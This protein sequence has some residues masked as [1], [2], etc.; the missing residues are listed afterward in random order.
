[1]FRI[2]FFLSLFSPFLVFS[3]DKKPFVGHDVFLEEW[4]NGKFDS[5]K[6][7]FPR[8]KW[9]NGNNGVIPE[10]LEFSEDIVF[11]KKKTVLNFYGNGDEYKGSLVG[12]EGHKNR[13]GSMIVSKRFFASGIYET[14]FKIGE[15]DKGAPKGMVP[16]IW[17]YA[18]R[19][20]KHREGMYKKFDPENPSYHPIL[21]RHKWG[22]SE[23][24]S[25][26]DFPEF[27][28][29]QKLGEALF[30]TFLNVNF[31]SQT[32]KTPSVLDGKYHTLKMTWTTKLTPVPEAKDS[33]VIEENGYCWVQSEE[34]PF[35]KYRGNPLKKLGKDKYVAYQGKEIIYELDGEV[36][37]KSTSFVPAMAAQFTL[38]VWFPDWGG[39]A[40]WSRAK[41]SIASVKITPLKNEGDCFG[42]LNQDL[43]D[44][45]D[46][47]GNK[48]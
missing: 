45:F 15:S 22:G 34:I 33:L 38:G 17:T 29:D 14:V 9:G 44:N 48:K 6:W 23:Y 21:D 19:F 36:I 7:Y 3:Q 30:N 46:I 37:G 20:V 25:E 31:H 1:M 10:N 24:W 16:A 27:G 5:N 2:L 47:K 40:P 12:F 18:Y 39:K 8:K 11:G 43:K 42:F 41:M 32:I 13:V 28:K 4:E 35:E 26:I